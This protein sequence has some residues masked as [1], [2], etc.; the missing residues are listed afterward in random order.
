MFA[1]LPACYQ[2]SLISEHYELSMNY[3]KEV[4]SLVSVSMLGLGGNMHQPI[5]VL[6]IKTLK[7]FENLTVVME[8]IGSDPGLTLIICIVFSEWQVAAVVFMVGLF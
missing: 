4:S 7:C 8:S 3:I 5:A 1:F 2:F 6:K